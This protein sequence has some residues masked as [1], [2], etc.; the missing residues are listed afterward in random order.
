[1]PT[2]SQIEWRPFQKKILK[3][4]EGEADD[5]AIHWFYSIQGK[6]GKS[7]VAKELVERYGAL[8]IDPQ[9]AKGSLELIRKQLKKSE[10]FF[11]KPVLVI[12]LGRAASA[13]V[14]GLY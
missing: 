6:V 4:V 13:Q 12:D 14:K 7:R 8:I 2:A 3:I 9:K 10:A 1:M 5:R 11:K